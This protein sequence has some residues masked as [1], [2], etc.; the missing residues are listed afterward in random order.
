MFPTTV[1]AYKNKKKKFLLN[2]LETRP[3]SNFKQ[4]S[5]RYSML[6]GVMYM[7]FAGAL[8]KN[9]LIEEITLR[10]C[11]GN[12]LELSPE[13]FGPIGH[14][15]YTTRLWDLL[16]VP[17][18][19]CNYLSFDYIQLNR[20]V[21]PSLNAA[22]PLNIDNFELSWT[23]HLWN[24]VSGT[25]FHNYSTGTAKTVQINADAKSVIRAP[26]CPPFSFQ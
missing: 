21:Q 19:P 11:C 6:L 2:N 20:K 12:I 9:P 3:N 5:N 8:K 22:D 7:P 15:G 26:N 4:F 16:Q 18:V 24:N 1:F 17:S 14:T 25:R 23:A 10:L 13:P